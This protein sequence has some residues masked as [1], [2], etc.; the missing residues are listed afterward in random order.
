MFFAPAID[1]FRNQWHMCHKR[2]ANSRDA[3]IRLQTENAEMS[4]KHDELRNIFRTMD[5]HKAQDIRESYYKAVEGLY[6]LAESLE[7]ADSKQPST[8][9][10]LLEEHFI[11]LEAVEA[12][13][14]SLL[15]TIL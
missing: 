14:K 5:P 8:A 6:S 3:E 12:M 13:R 7:I 2:R 11:A 10:P 9:G 15:G 4:E 1:V